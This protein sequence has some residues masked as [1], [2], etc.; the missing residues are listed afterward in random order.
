M[1]YNTSI[2]ASSGYSPFFLMFGRKAHL[3]IDVIYDTPADVSTL[4]VFVQ[5]LQQT[6]KEAY[7]S[8]HLNTSIHQEQQRDTYNRRAHG[9]P[10]QPG[11]L[12]WLFNPKVPKGRAKKLHKPWSGPYKVIKRFSDNTYRIKDHLRQKWSIL[13]VSSRAYQEPDSPNICT[14]NVQF[15]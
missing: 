4:P 3:P 2:H 5:K 1:A 12:V 10:H 11:S 14:S 15:T 8:A 13:I 7:A 6:L 9:S